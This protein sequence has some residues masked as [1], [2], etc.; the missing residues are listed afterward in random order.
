MFRGKSYWLSACLAAV[1]CW[2]QVPASPTQPQGA[3]QG[4]VQ[5]GVASPDAVALTLQDAIHRG[6]QYN[7][8][9]ISAGDT[10]RQARAERLASLAQLL[11]DLTPMY[12]RRCS[13]SISPPRGFVS[14]FRSR[15]FSF[16]QS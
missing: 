3:F 2:A 10:G 7:L 5:T 6:V 14:A 11:P 13:K 1:P 16:Q 4:S 15:D 12:G 8:G 9:V